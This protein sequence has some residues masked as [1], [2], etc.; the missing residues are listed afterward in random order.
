MKLVTTDLILATELC[1]EKKIE[2]EKQTFQKSATEQKNSLA[3]TQ[4][5]HWKFLHQK[6][7]ARKWNTFKVDMAPLKVKLAKTE[8]YSAAIRTRTRKSRRMSETWTERLK[9]EEEMDKM[10]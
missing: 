1:K 5:E 6:K 8:T 3:K 4:E 2:T 7:W 10:C 9:T